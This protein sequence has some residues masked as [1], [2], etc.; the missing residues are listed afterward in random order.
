MP[1]LRLLLTLLLLPS[2]LLPQVSYAQE[3][4]L[5]KRELLYQ[6]VL[7]LVDKKL[8]PVHKLLPP[9][10]VLMVEQEKN[11]AVKAELRKRITDIEGASNAEV[12]KFK[13]ELIQRN[14]AELNE[15]RAELYGYL[16]ALTD[17]EV[18]ELGEF[19]R[20]SRDYQGLAL[21][22]ENAYTLTEKRAALKTAL[23][24]DLSFLRTIYNKKIGLS[25][26]K[27][28]KRDLETNLQFFE[29]SNKNKDKLIK[30][31]LIVLAGVALVSW[32]IASSVHGGRY[33]R[34]KTQRENE[35]TA[36]KRDLEARYKA[37]EAEL[38][39]QEQNYLQ[40]NGFVR[41]V[42]GT[43]SQPD[44]RLCNRY[45]YQLFSGTKHC[46][47][48]CQKSNRD[49]RETMHEPAVCTSSFIP[50]DCYDPSEYWN[51]Y[52]QGKPI[53]YNDGYD[54]GTY[55]GQR[56]GAEDGRDEGRRD[57]EDDGNDD[58]YDAG[59]D[60]GYDDG[61][62]RGAADGRADSGSQKSL[63]NFIPFAKSPAYLKGFRDG[64]EQYQLLNLNF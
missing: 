46:Q 59:Y 49:G 22:F 61:Y 4:T 27:A 25:T 10:N 31:S 48:Y 2:L 41:T 63:R 51:A 38:T 9:G 34:A 52:A 12:V 16:N 54:D 39:L 7:S 1:I 17:R 50:A 14:E 21:D 62:S 33:N 56:H 26:A 8:A 58:G 30:I 23:A 36:L 40:D 44:S 19:L 53:G 5:P 57:G 60:D 20:T 28:L 11:E 13:R 43:Y 37:Y 47:V 32:G 6:R 45:N 64:L 42:C 35:L 24:E 29:G 15:L 3:T 55:D 18:K